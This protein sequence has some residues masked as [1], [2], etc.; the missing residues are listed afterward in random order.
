MSFHSE[1]QGWRIDDLGFFF[2]FFCAFK[3]YK[4]AFEAM[5]QYETEE[6]IQQQ[7]NS[8]DTETAAVLLQI[9][10]LPVMLKMLLGLKEN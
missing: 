6:Q 9:P 2:L 1:A 10:D 5:T 8:R 4:V 3:Y 7:I